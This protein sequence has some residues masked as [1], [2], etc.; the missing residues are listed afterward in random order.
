LHPEDRIFNQLLIEYFVESC[1]AGGVISF[2]D[3]KVK[4]SGHGSVSE[5]EEE[6]GPGEEV[7]CL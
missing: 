3:G 2:E 4:C 7:P 6:E 1:P 5:G